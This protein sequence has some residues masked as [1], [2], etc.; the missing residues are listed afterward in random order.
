[1]LGAYRVLFSRH[2]CRSRSLHSGVTLH[3]VPVWGQAE[4]FVDDYCLKPGGDDS[5]RSSNA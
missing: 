2:T 3:F 4:Q 1:M 5:T